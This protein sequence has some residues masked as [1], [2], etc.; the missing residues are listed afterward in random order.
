MHDKKSRKIAKMAIFFHLESCFTG[1]EYTEEMCNA[2]LSANAAFV[3]NDHGGKLLGSMRYGNRDAPYSEQRWTSH[4][5]SVC[6]ALYSRKKGQVRHDE[7]L[8]FIA[9]IV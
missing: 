6:T 7:H 9:D 8:F 2:M 3:A 1:L 4:A 5:V